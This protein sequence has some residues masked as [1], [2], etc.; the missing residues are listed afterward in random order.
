MKLQGNN[1]EAV[2][3]TAADSFRPDGASN[4]GEDGNGLSR[5]LRSSG[6]THQGSEN[7]GKKTS[8]LV[9]KLQVVGAV[10][11]AL[12]YIAAF[13]FESANESLSA[14]VQVGRAQVA[15]G[16]QLSRLNTEV[17]RSLALAAEEMDDA[18]VRL[19]LANNGV[20]YR[21]TPPAA[22]GGTADE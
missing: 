20:S 3:V 7:A 16:A 8:E 4:V 18:A 2:S 1:E 15:Q 19:M 13:T 9:G 12:L 11:L 10:G 17:I 22:A 21:Y 6:T 5:P 14:E